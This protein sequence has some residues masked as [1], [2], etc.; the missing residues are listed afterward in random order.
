MG[1][2]RN[3]ARSTYIRA[4]V[5]S[6]RAMIPRLYLLLLLV[7]ASASASCCGPGEYDY[8]CVL[9]PCEWPLNALCFAMLETELLRQGTPAAAMTHTSLGGGATDANGTVFSWYAIACS[10]AHTLACTWI[11]SQS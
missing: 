3:A 8:T 9:L 11:V 4:L 10:I 1:I 5:R 6:V 2:S 7:K